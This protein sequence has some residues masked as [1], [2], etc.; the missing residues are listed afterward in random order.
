LVRRQ[1]GNNFGDFFDFHGAQYNTGWAWFSERK[2]LTCQRSRSASTR[3][4]AFLRNT[5]SR[6]PRWR[7]AAGR[8]KQFLAYSQCRFAASPMRPAAKRYNMVTAS[9]GAAHD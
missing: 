4:S 3:C 1:L 6:G 5:P 8:H 2:G 7:E 9:G